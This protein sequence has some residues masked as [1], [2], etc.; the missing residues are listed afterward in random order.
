M[1]AHV[2]NA[3]RVARGLRAA[4][5]PVPARWADEVADLGEVRRRVLA[6]LDGGLAAPEALEAV[7]WVPGHDGT[8]GPAHLLACLVGEAWSLPLVELV[9]RRVAIQSAWAARRPSTAAQLGSLSVICDERRRLV[10]VDNTIATGASITATSTVLRAA[11]H[12]V[13]A[14]ITLTSTRS[15]A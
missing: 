9:T 2:G 10:L 13:A 7:A 1:G 4:C 15:A 5:R 14:L 6:W 3:R 11:G 8:P 12:D